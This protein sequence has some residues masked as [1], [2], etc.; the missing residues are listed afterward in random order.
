M[1]LATREGMAALEAEMQKYPSALGTLRVRQECGPGLYLRELFVP[2]GTIATGKIHKVG[3]ANIIAKGSVSVLG[4]GKRIEGPYWFFSPPGT[5][6]AI[7][8]HTDT[9]WITVHATDESDLD[10][11]EDAL[12]APTWDA[13]LEHQRR[14]LP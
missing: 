6:K 2:R 11:I 9:L 5:K 13:Y 12:I 14:Q 7:Y 1:N 4:E 10:K 3:H 8:A